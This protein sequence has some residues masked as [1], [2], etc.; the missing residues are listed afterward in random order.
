[1]P[2][3]TRY[4]PLLWALAL[5][6]CGESP[7]PRPTATWTP[8]EVAA[9]TPRQEAQR[10]KADDARQALF[11]RLMGRLTEA[12]G[13]QGPAGAVTVCQREA[14]DIAAAISKEKDVLIGRTSHRLRNPRNAPPDW[15]RPF[16]ESR[17]E[18]PAIVSHPD[19]RLGVLEPIRLKVACLTCHGDPATIAPEVKAALARDYPRDEATGF[20]DGDL[21]GWFWVEVP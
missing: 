3:A 1:M 8:V 21:R 13:S 12:L 4:T 17:R 15:A 6:A 19:G 20:R 5:S 10:T 7:T 11:T 18:A 14:P 16:V 2:A 9:L